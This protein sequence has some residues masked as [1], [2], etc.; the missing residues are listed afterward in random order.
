MEKKDKSALFKI[1]IFLKTKHLVN[2]TEHFV[3]HFVAISAAS[4]RSFAT[5]DK[6]IL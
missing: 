2:V 3:N 5:Y 6:A 1:W 4:L